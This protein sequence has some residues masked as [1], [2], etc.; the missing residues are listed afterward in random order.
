MELVSPCSDWGADKEVHADV[1]L[2]GRHSISWKVEGF[3][4]VTGIH[5]M[6]CVTT[7]ET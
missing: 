4:F 3:N 1:E 6:Q 2:W 5:R 7:Q